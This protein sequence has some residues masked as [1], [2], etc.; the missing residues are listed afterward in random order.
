MMSVITK[1]RLVAIV[2]VATFCVWLGSFIAMLVHP[3]LTVACVAFYFGWALLT[4][5][6]CF[7]GFQCSC[8]A[9]KWREAA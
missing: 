3:D 4:V 2:F 8:P 6:G 9:C 7:R 1:K 5:W